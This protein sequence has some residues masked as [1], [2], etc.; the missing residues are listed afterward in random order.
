VFSYEGWALIIAVSLLFPCQQ[1]DAKFQLRDIPGFSK[2]K[3]GMLD[4]SVTF[5]SEISTAII[6]AWQR[7]HVYGQ[8][9]VEKCLRKEQYS[10]AGSGT[11]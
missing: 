11:G 6:G 3:T 1:Q 9:Q 4:T 10:G 7:R 5:Y 8:S 2:T